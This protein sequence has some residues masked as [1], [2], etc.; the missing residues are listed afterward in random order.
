[1]SGQQIKSRISA[2]LLITLWAVSGCTQS[3][4]STNEGFGS[5]LNLGRT[6][7]A[8]E[9]MGDPLFGELR[10]PIDQPTNS[11]RFGS[12]GNSGPF[13]RARAQSK[14]PAQG[15][16]SADERVQRTPPIG[17]PLLRGSELTNASMAAGLSERR[18]RESDLRLEGLESDTRPTRKS[19]P[20]S[21]PNGD[22]L[23]RTGVILHAP[24]ESNTPLHGTSLPGRD[25]DSQRAPLRAF[26][27]ELAEPPP[28]RTD[29]VEEMLEELKR[30]GAL[31]LRLEP[32]EGGWHCSCA[33]RS[34]QNE[35]V[36]R[37]YA[38]TDPSKAEAVAMVLQQVRRQKGH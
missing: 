3:R 21:T 34:R 32:T 13:G 9:P 30:H 25:A 2:V 18:G 31:E 35:L 10:G 27:E 15:K 29:N 8:P 26:G 38:A 20:T 14:P 28:A 37:R 6:K 16:S 1:M 11:G 12:L 4:S 19:E 23:Q 36:Q 22:P 24:I 7:P 17:N 33:I 5:G